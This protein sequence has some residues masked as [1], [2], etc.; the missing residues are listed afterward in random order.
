MARHW[1]LSDLCSPGKTRQF[2][3][4]IRV[5]HLTLQTHHDIFWFSLQF[6]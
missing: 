6:R 4:I 2:L 3:D 1:A 5:A